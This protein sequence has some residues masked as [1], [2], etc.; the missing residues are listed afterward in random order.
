MIRPLMESRRSI[1]GVNG[2][3]G[4][5]LDGYEEE[6]A[7][8]E[9]RP[10]ALEVNEELRRVHTDEHRQREREEREE[11][12]QKFGSNDMRDKCD[13]PQILRVWSHA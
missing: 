10:E 12:I 13:H 6:C 1:R 3:A 11:Q 8:V 4:L 9:L 5:D 7:S 2:G